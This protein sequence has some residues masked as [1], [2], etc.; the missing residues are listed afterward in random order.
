MRIPANA[1]R[2]H[3]P[4]AGLA[5]NQTSIKITMGSKTTQSNVHVK[6][7]VVTES[8]IIVARCR[9]H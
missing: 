5:L 3:H 2:S 6:L 1:V 8:R 9:C 7:L 4:R